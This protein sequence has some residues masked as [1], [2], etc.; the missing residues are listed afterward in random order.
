MANYWGKCTNEEISKLPNYLTFLFPQRNQKV[1][2]PK[3]AI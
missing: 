3:G 1:K 2:N